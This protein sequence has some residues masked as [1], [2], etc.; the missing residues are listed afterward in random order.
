MNINIYIHIY[1]N[2][3]IYTY[4][5]P[6]IVICKQIDLYYSVFTITIMLL[7]FVGD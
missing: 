3:Y 5:Y 4:I 7:L 2:I 6:N 1:I